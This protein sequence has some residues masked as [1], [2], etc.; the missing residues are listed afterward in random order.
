MI[1]PATPPSTSDANV[2]SQTL[3]TLAQQLNLADSGTVVAGQVTGSGAGSAIDV[4]RAGGR[5]GHLSSVDNAD[6][7]NGQIVV[8]QALYEQLAE[9]KSGSYGSLPGATGRPE[10]GPGP[11]RDRRPPRRRPSSQASD[12]HAAAGGRQVSRGARHHAGHRRAWPP[13]PPRAPTGCSAAGRPRASRPGP[14]PTTAVSRSRCWK[15]RRWRPV[16]ALAAAASPG[17]PGRARAALLAAA[18]GAAAFGGYDDLA[19]SGDRR[20]FRG[21]LGA[22]AHGELTTG[23]A[24]LGGIGATGL[25]ASA[26]LGGGPVDALLNAGLIAGGANLVNLFDLRPGR[27]SKVTVASGGLLAAAAPASAPLAAVPVGAALALLGEDLGGAGHARRRR[28]E[29]ARRPARHGRGGGPAAAGPGRA[30]HR[31]H[32]ADRGQRGGQL[33]QG[34]RADPAAA[35]AGHARPAPGPGARRRGRGGRA[36]SRPARRAG[37]PGGPRRPGR[38]AASPA[39]TQ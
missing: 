24:K 17:L 23:A 37:Q 27:A 4:M 1:I 38:A 22:L 9:G 8:A 36:A 11:V 10:P 7:P 18:A 26:L 29:R 21:H 31:H 35:L 34:D 25:A 15:A 16:P 3:V 13:R 20:G 19:G 6:T 2:A 12:H 28:G 33:H 30:A 5:G 39:S 32:R 14:G